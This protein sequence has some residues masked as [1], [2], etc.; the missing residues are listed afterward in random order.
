MVSIHKGVHCMGRGRGTTKNVVEPIDEEAES[1]NGKGLGASSYVMKKTS[2][3]VLCSGTGHVRRC[4]FCY[5]V[6]GRFGR[7]RRCQRECAVVDGLWGPTV[8]CA[9]CMPEQRDTG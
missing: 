5:Y 7:H 3:P 6:D 1:G 4:E 9:D 8:C 2:L